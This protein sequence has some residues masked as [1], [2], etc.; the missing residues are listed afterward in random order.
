MRVALYARYSSEN[1]KDSSIEQQMRLLHE[2]VAAERWTIAG[3]Y[4]D[5]ALSGTNMLRPGLQ[6][7][8]AASQ[9]KEFEVILSE[10]IDRLSRDLADIAVMHKRLTHRGIRIVTLMEGE[11][12]AMHV[13][14]KG[15]HSEWYIKDLSKRTYRGL[16]DRALHGESAGGLSYGYDI[17]ARY[18]EKRGRR[19]G[20]L[21]TVNEEQA[22]VVRRIFKEYSEGKSPKRIAFELNEEGVA[23]P[24]GG[25]WS[26]STIYGNRRR[27]TGILRNSLYVGRQ[28][29]NK[30]KFT[31]DPDTGR[32]TGTLN[33][34]SEWVWADVPH[35]RII[36]DEL[37]ERVQAKQA[38]LD[39]MGKPPMQRRPK[40]LFSFLLKCG[41]CGGGVAKVS[42]TQYGCAAARN[43]GTCA[44]R[45]TISERKLEDIILGSLRERLMDP[46]LCEVF[47][48]E[49]TAHTNRLRHE[50]NA[51]LHANRAELERTEKSIAK[52]I[53]AIK[54]G[55]DP[56]LIRDEINGLQ[57]KKLELETALDGTAEEP[58]FIH[59]NMA[60]RYHDEVQRLIVSFNEPEH[61]QASAELIRSL[62]EKIVLT[63]NEDRSALALDLYGDLAGI[64]HISAR[65]GATHNAA[66]GGPSLTAVTEIQQAKLLARADGLK[67]AAKVA[68]GEQVA[69]SVEPPLP[70]SKTSD[71]GSTGWGGRIR[72]C[73]CRYQK[74]VPYHL[75]TPQQASGL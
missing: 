32:E 52:L 22:A 58:V 45:L 16:H 7:M 24:R 68:Y 46:N 28:C 62:I 4:E 14:M 39:R 64:L 75:A 72:T 53:E 25:T 2:R 43:K 3:E 34:E 11:I 57:T 74:P 70:M 48:T 27:E 51:A 69:W 35:L 55:I 47:C 19:V 41:E 40:K 5:K 33:D 38:A 61:R 6:R 73:E 56:V 54:N 63:P 13:A 42:A 12:T 30:Q 20:G 50:N 66:S 60:K 71:V 29:W 1:Q 26:A 67:N 9:D 31:K 37:W 65:H 17:E 59:P 49:Y 15:S 8:L 36:E 23:G 21:R 18:D 10:S 44:N